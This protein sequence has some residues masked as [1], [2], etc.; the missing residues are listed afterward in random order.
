MAVLERK[1]SANLEWKAA[2]A[3]AF[4]A[5]FSTFGVVDKD[6]DVTLKSAI[7]DGKEIPISAY[8]HTS[9]EGSL[10]VGKGVISADEHGAY[11]DGQ[12]FLDTPQGK[13]HYETLKALGFSEWSYGFEVKSAVTKSAALAEFPGASRILTDL[14]IFEVSPV[15]RGAGEDTRLVDIKSATADPVRLLREL[16]AAEQK[17]GRAI[18]AARRERI[19]A[20]VA[21]ART[22]ADELQALLDETDPDQPKGWLLEA[23]VIRIHARAAKTI[24]GGN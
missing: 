24:A 5:V 18:A 3:G 22:A 15:L 23:E 1:R 14:D 21:A 12:F 20:V 4:R 10:P 2:Q 16:V 17:D 6:G 9:W 11:V 7:P 8:M 19:A 13:A